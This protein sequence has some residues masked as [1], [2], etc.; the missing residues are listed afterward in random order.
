MLALWDY[1]FFARPKIFL[2]FW[3]FLSDI[4]G[5]GRTP[6]PRSGEKRRNIMSTATPKQIEFANQIMTRLIEAIRSHVDGDCTPGAAESFIAR[7]HVCETNAIAWIDEFKSFGSDVACD[8]ADQGVNGWF[9][10]G[11]QS[12]RVHGPKLAS[13]LVAE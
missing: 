1:F 4:D 5:E 12:R 10:T 7:L 11:M 2:A 9:W 3:I 8:L 6:R 13:L